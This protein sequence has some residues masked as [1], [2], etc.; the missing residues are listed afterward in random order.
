MGRNLRHNPI[1]QKAQQGQGPVPAPELATALHVSQAAGGLVPTWDWGA[2]SNVGYGQKLFK[3][4][5]FTVR[6]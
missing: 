5:I 2:I 3:K 6:F 4:Q 1:C